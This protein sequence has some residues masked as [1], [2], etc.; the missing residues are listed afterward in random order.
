MESVAFASDGRLALQQSDVQ[1]RG[2]AIECR[3]NAEDPAKGFMPDAG[4]IETY[5]PP[6]GFGIRVDSHA[7]G[8][9][10]I[11]P[12]Y[13]SLVAKIIAHAADRDECTQR[14]LR[15]LDELWITGIKTNVS[16][17]HAVLE[18]AAFQHGSIGTDYLVT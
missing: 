5:V 15:A 9:C 18:S 3:I 14:M 6:G 4:T 12:Q 13:D 10:T 2:H 16:F 7:F 11:P 1:F 8:G 17:F